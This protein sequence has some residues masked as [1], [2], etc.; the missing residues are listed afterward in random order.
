[1]NSC[2]DIREAWSS[3]AFAVLN[4]KTAQLNKIISFNYSVKIMD[5]VLERSIHSLRFELASFRW[6]V[7]WYIQIEINKN[8]LLAENFAKIRKTV[9]LINVSIV[10]IV[11]LTIQ[12]NPQD[13]RKALGR[14]DLDT[15]PQRVN[16]VRTLC[17]LWISILMSEIAQKYLGTNWRFA[18]GMSMS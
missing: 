10:L 8:Q 2:Q 15:G 11:P 7:I 16:P 1:M 6:L 13:C 18:S 3:K 14:V 4:S 12:E 9:Y 17:P 5:L